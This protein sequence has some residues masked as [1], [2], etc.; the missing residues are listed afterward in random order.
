[1]DPKYLEHDALWVFLF[2][3]IFSYQKIPDLIL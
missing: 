1:M 2:F 3:L